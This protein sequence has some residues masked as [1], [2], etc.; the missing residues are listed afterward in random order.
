[1]WS[2]KGRTL[3]RRKARRDV[4]SQTMNA[5]ML[6]SGFSKLLKIISIILLQKFLKPSFA[7]WPFEK[8]SFSEHADEPTCHFM[9]HVLKFSELGNCSKQTVGYID[10]DGSYFEFPGNVLRSQLGW[11]P[12]DYVPIAFPGGSV[13]KQI[14]LKCKRSPPTVQETQVGSLCG[15]GSLK[16]EMAIHSSTLAWRILWAEE[17]DGLQPVGS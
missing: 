5:Y 11:C 7:N 17:P 1:M 13:G 4:K 9:C 8:D 10:L 12:F 16:K 6:S 15:E 3:K 14:C 2:R